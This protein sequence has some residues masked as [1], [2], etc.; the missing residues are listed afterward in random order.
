MAISAERESHAA[1]SLQQTMTRFDAHQLHQWWYREARRGDRG[2]A[3]LERCLLLPSCD[4]D[5]SRFRGSSGLAANLE[6]ARMTQLGT[7]GRPPRIWASSVLSEPLQH[8]RAAPR[9]TRRSRSSPD[10]SRAARTLQCGDFGRR[11]FRNPG[12]SRLRNKLSSTYCLNIYVA[13]QSPCSGTQPGQV[14]TVRE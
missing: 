3:G 1:S 8:V 5:I 9:S 6:R 7:S 11:L 10:S 13:G 12:A 4:F 14:G 2:S